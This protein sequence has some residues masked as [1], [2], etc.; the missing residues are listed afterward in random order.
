MLSLTSAA[1]QAAA[2]FGPALGSSGALE[3]RLA[4]TEAEVRAAQALR[5]QV[6]YEEMHA[7]PTAEMRAER[8]DFD[9]FDEIC[10]HLLVLDTDAAGPDG[11]PLVV[12]CYRLLRGDVAAANGGFYSAA[13]YD[14]APMLARAAAKGERLLEL[15]R[16]CVHKDYRS[17]ASMQM[18]WRGLMPY[19]LHHKIDIMFG[20]ASLPGTDPET[21]KLELA[22]LHHFYG[23]PEGE[24]VRALPQHY[25]S[26]NTMPKEAIDETRATHELAPLIKGYVRAGALIG[27]GAVIDRQFGT[28]DVLIYFPV[29]RIEPRWKAFFAKRRGG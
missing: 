15:G 18:L 13:E 4:T 2:G 24:R 12:G 6:F 22:F 25:V 8:R 20:C 19:L 27:D 17:S 16:S 23:M 28:V 9:A 5:Y 10:D 14:I 1:A 11:R 3:V 21:L 7:Q 29:S 26:M